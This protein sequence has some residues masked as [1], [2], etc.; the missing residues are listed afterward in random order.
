MKARRTNLKVYG[1]N[2]Q[3]SNDS[4]EWGKEDLL[5]T[6]AMFNILLRP[7]DDAI[8]FVNHKQRVALINSAATKLFGYECKDL[9]GKKMIVLYASPEEH[10][11]HGNLQYTPSI[12]E[13]LAPFQ[14]LYKKKNGALFCGETSV[15]KVC[16]KK[17]ASLDSR[18]K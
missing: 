6:N 7:K 1:K 11:K 8:I 18:R 2:R 3:P 10:E 16:D 12:E 5:C 13:R 14:V 15:T 17:G 9:I 4:M